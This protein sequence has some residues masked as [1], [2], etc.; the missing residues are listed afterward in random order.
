MDADVCCGIRI[1][2]DHHRPSP[3]A[4]RSPSEA[5]FAHQPIGDEVVDDHPNRRF[6]QSDLGRQFSP[7]PLP[8][9]AE[10]I[11]HARPVNSPQQLGV[12]D[13]IHLK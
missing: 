11:E 13:L 7:A 9:I 12:A 1:D 3:T 4:T 8:P 2:L 10:R 6:R 5:E